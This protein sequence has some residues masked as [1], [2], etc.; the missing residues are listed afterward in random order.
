MEAGK[1]GSCSLLY[2]HGVRSPAQALSKTL[3]TSQGQKG[4][5]G[6][7]GLLSKVWQDLEIG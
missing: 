7:A 2:Q 5:D 3:E 6:T 1:R 4:L